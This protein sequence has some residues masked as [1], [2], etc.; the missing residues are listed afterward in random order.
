LGIS[1]VAATEKPPLS[2]EWV[3]ILYCLPSG[4]CNHARLVGWGFLKVEE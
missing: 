1:V 2:V 4:T 3:P